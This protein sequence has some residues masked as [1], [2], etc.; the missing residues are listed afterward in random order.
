MKEFFIPIGFEK[1]SIKT[2]VKMTLWLFLMQ[3]ITS[4]ATLIPL[5]FLSSFFRHLIGED[6]TFVQVF[7]FIDD[8]LIWIFIFINPVYSMRWVLAR[9]VPKN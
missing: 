8:I 6:S 7:T 2:A 9:F 1:I 3:A 4:M 5:V